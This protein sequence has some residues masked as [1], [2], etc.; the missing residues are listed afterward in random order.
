MGWLDLIGK[1]VVA[2]RG[3]KTSKYGRKCTPLE[4]VLFDDGET[5]ILIEEQDQY[6]Y[7]DCSP[8]ARNVKAIKDK[9]Q[10]ERLMA[11]DGC[12]EP[13]EFDF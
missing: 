3:H 4:Y 8:S 13:T 1:K 9:T 5:F 12:E 7:H 11:K 10:W 6:E 2:L